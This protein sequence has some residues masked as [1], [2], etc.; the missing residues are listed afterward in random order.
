MKLKATDEEKVMLSNLLN[1]IEDGGLQNI[2]RQTLFSG[3]DILESVSNNRPE[4][5]NDDLQSLKR[6]K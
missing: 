5:N 6:T 1:E 4:Y 2:L 3:M